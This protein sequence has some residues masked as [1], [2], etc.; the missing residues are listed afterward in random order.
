M[1]NLDTVANA[2][3]LNLRQRQILIKR[4]GNEYHSLAEIGE[5]HGISRERARQIE[6]KI[7]TKLQDSEYKYV[8]TTFGTPCL[9]DK[10]TNNKTRREVLHEK[11]VRLCAACGTERVHS[12]SNYCKGCINFTM[13]CTNCGN[14]VTRRRAHYDF[15]RSRYPD[16]YTTGNVFCNRK[17]FGQ[18]AGKH[19]GTGNPE[20]PHRKAK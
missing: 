6:Q 10:V 17:C 14:W 1:S 8:L 7:T 18:Y 9:I 16:R 20:H 12:R 2:A 11:V 5:E 3:N 13:P 15:T 19:Y 4:Y